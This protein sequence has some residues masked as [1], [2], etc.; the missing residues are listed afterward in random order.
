MLE[1]SRA[2][3]VQHQCGGQK[4]EQK[5]VGTENH[6]ASWNSPRHTTLVESLN[7]G[8][9]DARMNSKLTGVILESHID[10]ADARCPTRCREDA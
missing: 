2:E 10:L 8:V 5:K 3:V 1:P 6:D 7:P 4:V 9:C